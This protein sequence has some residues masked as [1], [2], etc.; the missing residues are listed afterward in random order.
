M[1]STNIITEGKTSGLHSGITYPKGTL[2]QR[3]EY[4]PYGQ[5][6]FVLNPNLKF[7]PRYTGQ[8][9]D[10]ETGLYYYKARY[11]N[12]VLARFIQADTVVPDAKNLQAYNRY[13][14]A[15]NNPLKYTDPSGHSFGSWFKKLAGAFIGALVGALITVLTAGVLGPIVAAML[16]GLIGGAI[17]GGITGGIKGALL[18]ALFGALGGLA[19]GGFS[20]GLASMGVSK[21]GQYAILGGVGAGLAYGTGGWRGLLTFGAG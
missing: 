21:V 2:V 7:D 19:F 13:A 15:A 14:Y 9:Y 5:E 4:S 11:Y 3:I 16:G 12:P 20:S 8:Q 6:Q 1:G 17:T 10:V 18:G